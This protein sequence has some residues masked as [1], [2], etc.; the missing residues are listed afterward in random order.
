MRYRSNGGHGRP[1]PDANDPQRDFT[2][3]NLLRKIHSITASA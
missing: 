3:F 2:A 1:D